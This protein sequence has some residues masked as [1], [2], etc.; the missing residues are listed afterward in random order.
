ML[1]GIL[2]PVSIRYEQSLASATE[3]NSSWQG[4]DDPARKGT[5]GG[6]EDM[7]LFVSV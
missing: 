6:R 2:T 1:L 4:F 7:V 5:R 3:T